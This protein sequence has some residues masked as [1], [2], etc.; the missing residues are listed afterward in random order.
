MITYSCFPWRSACYIVKE[1]SL[2]QNFS[3]VHPPA[4]VLPLLRGCRGRSR[5]P[6]HEG[7]KTLNLFFVSLALLDKLIITNASPHSCCWLDGFENVCSSA[8]TVTPDNLRVVLFRYLTPRTCH[9]IRRIYLIGQLFCS[10]K[11]NILISS[12]VATITRDIRFTPD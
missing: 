8:Q 11:I 5:L 2:S 3:S 4:C 9:T 10:Y 1:K 6:R 12:F 7:I